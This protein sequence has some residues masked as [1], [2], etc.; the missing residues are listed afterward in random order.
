MRVQVLG[1]TGYPPWPTEVR[2]LHQRYSDAPPARLRILTRAAF[3]ASKTVAWRDRAAPEIS[4]IFGYLLA[5]VHWTPRQPSYGNCFGLPVAGDRTPHRGQ[6]GRD[7]RTLRR[8]YG[9]RGLLHSPDTTCRSAE[10][11][12]EVAQTSDYL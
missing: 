9:P 6:V 7:C 10:L 12:P 11:R 4:P 8:E 1:S 5:S 2:Q 3:A